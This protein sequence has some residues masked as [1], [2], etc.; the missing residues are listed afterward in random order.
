MAPAAGGLIDVAAAVILILTSRAPA[1]V[2]GGSA[3]FVFCRGDA[4]NLLF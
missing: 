4:P 2:F 3:G 1:K